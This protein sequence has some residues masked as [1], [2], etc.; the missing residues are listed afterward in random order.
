MILGIKIR[1]GGCKERE[2][3]RQKSFNCSLYPS[4]SHPPLSPSRFTEGGGKPVPKC[5]R[6]ATRSY[7]RNHDAFGT[8]MAVLKKGKGG[9]EGRNYFFILP[10]SP[11]QAAGGV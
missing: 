9:G 5:V 8:A 2:R 10:P 3:E 6:C 11:L 7:G 4:V 1:E